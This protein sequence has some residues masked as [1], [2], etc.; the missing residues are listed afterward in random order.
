VNVIGLGNCGCN[1]AK[2]FGRYPQYNVFLIDTEPHHG[3]NFYL[4]TEQVNPEQYERTC[5]DL[6]N[7]LRCDGEVIL[8]LGGSGSI[9]AACLRVL[10]KVKHCKIT[11]LYIKSDQDLL[12][13]VGRLQ[14]RA[15]FH[16][17]QEYAR[18]GVFERIFLI[19]NTLVADMIG[20]VSIA[21]YYQTINQT[22]APVVHFINVFNNS[23]PVMSTF[24]SL[25]DTSRICTLGIV[26]VETGEEKM[27]FPL[28]NRTETRYY[29]AISEKS[30]K[31]DGTLHNKIKSQVKKKDEKTSFG[32]FETGYDNNFCYSLAC[33]RQIVQI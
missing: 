7:F 6:G 24:Y 8:A 16:V 27:F 26:D 33:S 13:E 11:I 5:P 21:N 18:S 1:I 12:S 32:I 14:Q 23:K 30:L 22:I 9:S 20:E 28:D 31:E 19:D 25:A 17:L 29:Y 10:E 15:T 4:L 2:E 3:E